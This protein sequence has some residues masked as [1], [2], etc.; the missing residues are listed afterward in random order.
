MIERGCRLLM[1][2]IDWALL[3]RGIGG[4]MEGMR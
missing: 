4:A 1:I 2:G 3:Q